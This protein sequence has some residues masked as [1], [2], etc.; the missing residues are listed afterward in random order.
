MSCLKI[1]SILSGIRR[2]T[3]GIFSFHCKGAFTVNHRCKLYYVSMNYVCI[4]CTLCFHMQISMPVI[5]VKLMQDKKK[6]NRA[7][8]S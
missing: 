3:G 1:I 4:V 8:H 2:G 5:T 7:A 6:G